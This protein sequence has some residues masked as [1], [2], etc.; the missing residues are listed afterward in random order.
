MGINQLG[1]QF[2]RTATPVKISTATTTI[3]SATGTRGIATLRVLGGTMG[4]VT[5]YDNGAASGTTIVPT[6][7]PVSGAVLI[8]NMPFNN[9]LTVVTAAATVIVGTYSTTSEHSTS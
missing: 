2:A 8:E 5:I 4:N 7:T 6:V 1:E 9:G 3:V